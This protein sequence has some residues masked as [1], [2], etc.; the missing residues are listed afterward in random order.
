L[1]G[2]LGQFLDTLSKYMQM[3]SSTRENPFVIKSYNFLLTSNVYRNKITLDRVEN[4]VGGYYIMDKN[5]KFFVHPPFEFYYALTCISMEEALLKELQDDNIKLEGRY[6]NIME[7]I[8]SNMSRYIKQELEYFFDKEMSPTIKLGEVILWN[9]IISNPDITN[10]SAL[11]SKIERSSI[12][13]FFSPLI[14]F[15]FYENCNKRIS[16]TKDW[17]KIKRDI[18]LMLYEIKSLE[19]KNGKGKERLIESLENPEETK[20]RYCLL[21]RQ[22]YEKAYKNK[23]DLILS[24]SLS[25]KDAYEKIFNKNRAK[26]IR[27]Y[28]KKDINVFSNNVNIHLSYIWHCGS[29]YWATGEDVEWLALGCKTIEY[30]GEEPKKERVLSFLKKITDRKR[31]EIIELLSQRD[32]Y[33]NEIAEELKISAATASYHLANLQDYGIVDFE[34]IDHRFYYHLDKKR[35]REL[36]KEAMEVMTIE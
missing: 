22:F 9:F 6:I 1:Y 34:R 3:G 17:E 8:K 14:S 32:C 2:S 28:F 20:Q 5:I 7:E 30:I 18:K 26:F 11:I 35:L 15:I 33:V 23:E 12:E 10:I 29:E 24:I 19:F 13:D 16:E 21:L 31:I 36:F 4:I 25:Y 27:D